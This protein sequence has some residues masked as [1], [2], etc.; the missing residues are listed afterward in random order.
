MN[1]LKKIPVITK[2]ILSSFPYVYT[3]N[4]EYLPKINI[5]LPLTIN[6][7]VNVPPLNTFIIDSGKF[8]LLDRLL[9]KL[10]QE[11]HRILLYFQMTKMM[12]LVE[13]YLVKKEYSYCRLDGSS[14]ISYRRDT[15]NDWQTGDKFIFL[16][17]T[18]AGGLG[19]NL[20]AA[21]TVIF[22]DSD[23]NP[24]VDQQAMDRAYRIGQTKDVTVYRL[25]TRNT[26]EER[27]MEKA[28]HKGNLQ[29]M[30]IKGKIFEGLDY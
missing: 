21:D 30:V 20:T 22:Y 27:V 24:T 9:T 11:N 15:V 6:N 25:I 4:G 8:L 18:R 7:V 14:K 5:N 1:S 28:L 12:D 16:L 17:S 3:N 29:K 23:W 26:I 19:I 13:D 2:N 10:K